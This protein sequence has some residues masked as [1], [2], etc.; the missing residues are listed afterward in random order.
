MSVHG[1]ETL[2]IADL[3]AIEGRG[4]NRETV[5]AIAGR[6]P[7]L[8]LWIDAGFRCADD[9]REWWTIGNAAAVFGSET[10]AS[11]AGLNGVTGHPRAILS[12]DFKGDV[13]LGPEGLLSDSSLWPRRVI[14]MTLDRVG[15]DTG[16]DI[17]RLA[18]A[19]R[20]AGERAIIAAGG[21][22]GAADLVALRAA[23]A[24]GVLIASALHDGKLEAADF[25]PSSGPRTCE[26]SLPP[27]TAEGVGRLD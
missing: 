2:Y 6:F 5:R 18:T 25:S 11:L 17:D 7:H 20:V 16:P 22:R 27:E 24:D 9:A 19:R 4:D 23:G 21:V 13:F 3:D 8:G 15:A 10:L 26:G 14:L 1:F 12:L